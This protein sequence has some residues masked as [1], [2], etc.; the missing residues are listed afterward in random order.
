MAR[1]RRAADAGRRSGPAGE[2]RWWDPADQAEVEA[3]LLGRRDLGKG[4]TALDM[5][6]N[7]ERQDPFG[8]DPASAAVRAAREARRLT[9]LDEGRAWR[10]RGDGSLVVVRVEAYASADES[11]HRA[12]WQAEGAACLDAVWRQR[13]KERDRLPGW[14]EARWKQDVDDE[15]DVPDGVDWLQ[16]EDQTGVH[17]TGVVQIYEHLTIWVGRAHAIVTLRHPQD[18]ALGPLAAHLGA[19]ARARLV[20]WGG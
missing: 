17:D 14:I 7:A 19:L 1:G 8:D 15:V 3:P 13:W 4:W 5:V 11:V 20:R 12:A 6:N 2:E 18:L 9:G 10:Q 16:V